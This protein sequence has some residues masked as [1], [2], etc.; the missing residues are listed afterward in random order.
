MTSTDTHAQTYESGL[1]IRRE[2]IGADYVERSL[3]SATDFQASPINTT[4]PRQR[5]QGL[6]PR[7]TSS[8]AQ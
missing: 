2:V 1:G 3:A 5:R 4:A 6:T 7:T 8:T